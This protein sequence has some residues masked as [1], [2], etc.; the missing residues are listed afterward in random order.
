MTN[1]APLAGQSDKAKGKPLL[2]DPLGS[3][4]QR[5]AC[6]QWTVVAGPGQLQQFRYV[7]SPFGT[8]PQRFNVKST[9]TIG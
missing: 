3:I 9:P 7:A 2:P 6:S 4:A 5:I 1:D 8:A